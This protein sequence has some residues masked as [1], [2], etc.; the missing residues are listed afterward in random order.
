MSGK[1]GK[2]RETSSQIQEKSKGKSTLTSEDF[3]ECA[4]KL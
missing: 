4:G 2:D 3:D 1:P